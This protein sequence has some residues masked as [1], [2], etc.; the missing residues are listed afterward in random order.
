MSNT[1]FVDHAALIEFFRKYSSN[2]RPDVI[3]LDV[4]MPILNG[5]DTCRTIKAE[6]PEI[7]S[8][9]LFFTATDTP[10]RQQAARQAGGDEFIKKPFTPD[11][12]V[13]RLDY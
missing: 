2:V 11:K 5:F 1:F 9:I 10:D 6:F 4:E 3:I 8:P 7:D 13:E 12:L